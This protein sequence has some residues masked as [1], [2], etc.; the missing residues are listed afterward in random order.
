MVS[1]ARI[2]RHSKRVQCRGRAGQGGLAH[3]FLN[4]D[5]VA[6]LDE[7][8]SYPRRGLVLKNTIASGCLP[9]CD[10]QARMR[11]AVSNKHRAATALAPLPLQKPLY[12]PILSE[13][14]RRGDIESRR[15][16]FRRQ[17]TRPTRPD[18]GGEVQSAH[19]SDLAP[20]CSLGVSLAGQ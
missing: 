4:E 20:L 14:S 8:R 13:A 7:R 5:L 3:L 9:T 19:A 18:A 15:P 12:K 10:S 1:R 2:K 16:G 11:T 17:S 6:Q